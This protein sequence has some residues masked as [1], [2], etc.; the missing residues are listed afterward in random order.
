M[1]AS[2]KL[3]H[4]AGVRVGSGTDLIGPGQNRRGLE[5]AL[6]AKALGPMGAIV[7]ATATNAAI[8]RQPDLG[9]IAEGK[10]ADLIGVDGDPLSEPEL[11]D[12]PDRVVLVIKDGKIMKDLRA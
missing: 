5:I 4:D 8:L 2:L 12:N 11:F 10:L 1:M 7:S 9:T 3:A 6:K